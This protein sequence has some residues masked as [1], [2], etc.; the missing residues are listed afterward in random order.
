MTQKLQVYKCNVCGNIVMVMHPSF[1]ELVCCG[2]PMQLLEEKTEDVGMEKHVPVI[3]RTATGVKVK[4][5]SIPHPMEG[6]HY[7]EW[8]ELTAD[9]KVYIK[10]L[11]PGDAPEAEFPVKAEKLSAREY[12]NIHGL[13]KSK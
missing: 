9:D 3:E 13:W 2:Q 8:I 5:G 6:N 1:G 7:I 12:C 4:V 10:F 11:K